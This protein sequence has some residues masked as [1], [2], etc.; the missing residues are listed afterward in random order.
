MKRDRQSVDASVIRDNNSLIDARSKLSS[1]VG[2]SVFNPSM[3][4]YTSAF[5]SE[6]LF[7]KKQRPQRTIDMSRDNSKRFDYG[8]D[9]SLHERRFDNISLP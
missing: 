1:Q 6:T 8:K 7:K 2:S 4:G 5:I 3:R 9:Y